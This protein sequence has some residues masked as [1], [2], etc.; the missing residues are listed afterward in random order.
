MTG[1]RVA[2]TNYNSDGWV[3]H[4]NT[5]LWR[6][7][8]PINGL[9]GI[10]PTGNAWLCQNLWWHYE[11]TRDT[12]YLASVYPAMKGA[13]QFFEDFLIP[14]S[15]NANWRVTN[16]SFSP[17]HSHPIYDISNV[18]GP[19]MDI[20]LIRELFNDVISASQVLGVDGLF[21]TNIMTLRSQLPPQQSGRL[22]QL[23]EWIK[24]V[25]EPGDTH[26]HMSH[27]VGL[28]PGETISPFYTPS[29]AAAAKVSTDIRG[30]GDIGWGKAWRANLR[31]RLLD[32]ERAY[33]FSPT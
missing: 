33:F 10:W 25:D 3:V 9:D 29:V 19:T 27:L 4:H 26:R 1:A 14:H 8:A 32:G 24:D 7:A 31:A 17:E 21:R 30:N 11:Y 6:G 23:R 5:D 15:T 22:G 18:E 16:P 13:A 28:W 20:E 2:K 12:N